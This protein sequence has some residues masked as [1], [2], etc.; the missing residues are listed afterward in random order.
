MHHRASC[1]RAT[2]CERFRRVPWCRVMREAIRERLG[3]GPTVVPD[4]FEGAIF[5]Q[6]ASCLPCSSQP[7]GVRRGSILDLLEVLL[8]VQPGAEVDAS[9][10]LVVGSS[11]VSAAPPAAVLPIPLVLRREDDGVLVHHATRAA[12]TGC[13]S[14]R[15]PSSC[16]AGRPVSVSPSTRRVWNS[17]DPRSAIRS[18]P[19]TAPRS[20]RRSRQC[21][22]GCCG[23]ARS[24]L[25]VAV[26]STGLA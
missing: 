21:G 17:C 14:W 2:S 11:E 13:C 18:F 22:S 10:V 16:D 20:V 19:V 25:R 6:L 26:G 7:Y 8:A 5:R 24:R 1:R 12:G 9:A 4:R 3:D 15:M 23:G